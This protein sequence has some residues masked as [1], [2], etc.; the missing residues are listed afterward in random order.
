M[1]Q[2]RMKENVEKGNLIISKQFMLYNTKKTQPLREAGF[3]A[4]KL[5]SSNAYFVIRQETCHSVL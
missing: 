3:F 4:L 5:F 1:P 2:L